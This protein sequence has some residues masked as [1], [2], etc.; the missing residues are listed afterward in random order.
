MIAWEAAIVALVGSV[1][2]IWPGVLVGRALGHALVR[3]GIAPPNFAVHADWKPAVAAIGIAIVTTL[4][5]VLAAGR[6]AARVPPTLALSDAAVEP[7]LVGPGRVVGGVLAI[8]GAVPLLAVAATTSTPETAAA[9]S[10]MTDICLVVAVG[11][12]GQF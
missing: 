5:A 2:G 7:R 11:F 12:L 8:A 9:T 3:H 10:E 1:A 4:L 6:R